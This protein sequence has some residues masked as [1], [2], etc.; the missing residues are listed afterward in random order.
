MNAIRSARN[1]LALL[2]FALAQ[3]AAAHHAMDGATPKNLMEGLLSGFAHPVI[4][5]DHLL[6]V[7]AIGVAAFYFGRRIATVAA[8]AACAFAGTLLHVQVPTLPYADALVAVSLIVLGALFFLRSEWLKGRA[9]MLLFALSG[10]AHGY[11]YGEA[12]VGAEATPLVAYL[13]GFTLVQFAIAAGGY[14][15]ARYASTRKPAFAFLKSAG[16]VL[17]AAGAG[18]L[19]LTVAG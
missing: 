11:A 18:F 6:F 4:G 3:P 7:V 13:V 8:F 16:G 10:L 5:V 17:A 1:A 2:L 14:H 19:A 9:A 15:L 12:I